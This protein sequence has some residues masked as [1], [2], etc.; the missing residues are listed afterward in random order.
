MRN[1]FD[2]ALVLTQDGHISEGQRRELLHGARA[3]C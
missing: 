2:E 3:V 1:G